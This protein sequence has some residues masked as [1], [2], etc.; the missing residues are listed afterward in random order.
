MS[1]NSNSLAG[2]GTPTY[3]ASAADPALA[4][5]FPAWLNNLADDV[6]LEGSMMDGAV[7][8]ADAVRTILVYIRKL[9]ERQEFHFA[10]PYGEK[11]FLEDYTA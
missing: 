11:G 5:Y 6:T 1:V 10:G 4:D 7:Q 9:Y 8:G 3:L 2:E